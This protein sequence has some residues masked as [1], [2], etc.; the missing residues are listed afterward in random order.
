MQI[1]NITDFVSLADLPNDVIWEWLRTAKALKEE[2]RAGGNQPTLKGKVLALVFQKPSLRTR[3]SFDVAM[4]HLGG[5]AIY[6]SPQ[7]IRLGERETIPDAA[8]VLSGYVN[9]I[10]A[11]VFDHQHI[12]DLAQYATVPVINGLSD[13]NHPAQAFS[14]IFTL[15]E[16]WHWQDLRGRH[17]VF[18]GDGNNVAHSLMFACARVGMRITVCTPPGYE[19]D[20]SVVTASRAIAKETGGEVRLAHDPVDA[21]KGADVIYTDVWA[22]M[23]QE[24]E[25]E[26]RRRVFSPYQVNQ[27][28]IAASGNKDV[29]VMHC[30]PAHRGEEITDE[31]IDGPHSIVFTQAHNRLHGQK[32]ILL[33]L[34]G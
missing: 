34:L 9:G 6:L 28:L 30:L 16:H 13:F 21:V 3:V 1:K 19:P 25:A 11:R 24:A 33:K 7:E 14:D 27:E 20:E 5:E 32:A 17:L 15:Y 8:R 12:L 2:W 10:M 26:K 22:S 23:G 18:V 31:V 29:L 4:R